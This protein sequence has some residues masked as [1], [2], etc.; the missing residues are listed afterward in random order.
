MTWSEFLVIVAPQTS[1]LPCSET[2]LRAP[3]PSRSQ[4]VSL[5]PVLPFVQ[6]HSSDTIIYCQR[7]F[8]SQSLSKM[9]TTEDSS[10]Q[11]CMFEPESD[12]EQENED[13]QS[14][15]P[16]TQ[17]NASQWYYYFIHTLSIHN[18]YL[19]YGVQFNYS[20]HACEIPIKILI[21][22]QYE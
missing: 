7:H 18:S 13:H 9:S 21:L 8:L 14:A 5:H 15:E 19:Q 6:F 10:I 22:P 2:C 3:P 12:V 4:S 20:I 16:C 11:P 1:R 17:M